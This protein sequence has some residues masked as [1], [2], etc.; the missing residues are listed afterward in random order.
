MT[1]MEHC[2]AVFGIPASI[3][4]VRGTQFKSTLFTKLVNVLITYRA[5]TTAQA[6]GLVERF[7]RQ[8]KAVLVAHGDPTKRSEVLPLVMLD[9]RTAVKANT[10]KN[11]CP[12]Q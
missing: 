8:L 7:H 2:I 1:F 4:T 3:T 6:N 9:I 11:T 12:P 5:R 10:Q